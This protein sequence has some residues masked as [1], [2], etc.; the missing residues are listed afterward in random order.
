[1][2]WYGG[3][4]YSAILRDNFD[5]GSKLDESSGLEVAFCVFAS[6][7]GF[8]VSFVVT[9]FLQIAEGDGG[10]YLPGSI[11]GG[12]RH[13]VFVVLLEAFLEVGGQSDVAVAGGRD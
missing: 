1:M 6:G 9:G 5:L 4:G 11:F 8:E 2:R 10:F 7:V 3:G 13:S 12:V